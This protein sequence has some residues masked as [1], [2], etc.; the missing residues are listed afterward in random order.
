[1]D[2]ANE[3]RIFLLL[4]QLIFQNIASGL[5]CFSLPKPGNPDTGERLK[6]V[7][8]SKLYCRSEKHQLWN[9]L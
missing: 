5:I 1:M 4:L 6:W 2:T 3:V 9:A 8:S 7:H